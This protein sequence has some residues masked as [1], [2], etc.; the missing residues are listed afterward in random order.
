MGGGG[1]FYI[2]VCSSLTTNYY[3]NLTVKTQLCVVLL[4]VLTLVHH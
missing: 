4:Q 2:D 1:V 3:M